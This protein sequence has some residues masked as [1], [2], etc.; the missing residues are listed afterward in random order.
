MIR[1]RIRVR[2]RRIGTMTGALLV[3]VLALGL[4]FY[5]VIVILAAFKVG[6]HTLNSVSAYAT[7]RDRLT[8]IDAGNITVLDRIIVAAAGLACLL[9]FAPLTWKALPRASLARQVTGLDTPGEHGR[10]ELAPRAIE[11][12]AEVAAGRHDLVGRAIARC[13]SGRI[14]VRVE[15]S[16]PDE[17][18]P[19]LREIQAR[20][21][22]TLSDH[23]LPRQRIDITLARLTA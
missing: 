17:I 10:T 8:E 18:T 2:G 11:R 7:I 20:V 23:G 12:A 3:S 9:V 19:V 6:P 21:Q 5:G 22:E 16:R 15:L 14:E 4:M 13:S 1:Q